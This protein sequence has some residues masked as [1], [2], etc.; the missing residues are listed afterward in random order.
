LKDPFEKTMSGGFERLKFLHASGETEWTSTG[1]SSGVMTYVMSPN[2]SRPADIPASEPIV[3]ARGDSILPFPPAAIMHLL[4]RDE[5][6][7][8]ELDPTI[9]K[10]ILIEEVVPDLCRLE[11]MK[12]KGV[13]MT[14][15]RDFAVASGGVVDSKAAKAYLFSTSLEHEKVP[16]AKGFVRGRLEVGAWVLEPITSLK[17]YDG[18][19]KKLGLPSYPKLPENEFLGA[20]RVSYLFRLSIG[21]SLPKFLVQQISAAQAK[22]PSLVSKLLEGRFPIATPK[23]RAALKSAIAALPESMATFGVAGA[24]ADV[25]TTSSSHSTTTTTTAIDA[26][27]S[28]SPHLSDTASHA[29]HSSASVSTTV[30][31]PV[32]DLTSHVTSTEHSHDISDKPLKQHPYPEVSFDLSGTW[33]VDKATSDTLEELLKE[34]GVPWI[35]RKAVEGLEVTTILRQ[36][37]SSEL[38]IE[39]RSRLGDHSSKISLNWKQFDVKGGDGKVVKVQ[40]IALSSIDSLEITSDAVAAVDAHLKSEASS[41]ST[42]TKKHC[43][44]G[45]GCIISTSILPGNLGVTYVQRHLVK[46]NLLRLITVYVKEGK[47]RAKLTR[48]LH[49]LNPETLHVLPQVEA[50]E[51]HIDEKTSA[52]VPK[53]TSV[54]PPLSSPSASLSTHETAT[55]VDPAGALSPASVGVTPH[56]EKHLHGDH[57]SSIESPARPTQPFDSSS[58]RP[59][60]VSSA[61]ETSHQPQ[62]VALHPEGWNFARWIPDE[63]VTKCET[64][65]LGFTGLRRLHHCRS[66]GLAFCGSCSPSKLPLMHFSPDARKKAGLKDKEPV[67]VCVPCAAPFVLSASTCGSAGGKVTLFGGNLGERGSTVQIKIASPFSKPVAIKVEPSW[68]KGTHTSLTFVMPPGV[69]KRDIYLTVDDRTLIGHFDYFYDPIELSSIELIESDGGNTILRGKNLPGTNAVDLRSLEVRVNGQLCPVLRCFERYTAVEINAPP[70]TGGVEAGNV[71]SVAVT[72]CAGKKP[73]HLPFS[74]APPHIFAVRLVEVKP[75]SLQLVDKDSIKINPCIIL[76]GASF[77]ETAVNI[78][79]TINGDPCEDL[80]LLVPHSKVRATVPKSVLTR[81]VS[82]DELIVCATVKGVKGETIKTNFV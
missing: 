41:P 47:V 33:R 6:S 17:S 23:G 70:G 76:Y 9:D 49:R 26:P 25:S 75:M 69:G 50:Q 81:A 53:P 79:L 55:I 42:P 51:T 40:A 18:L 77:G 57:P 5:K 34:M 11:H 10:K 48:Y 38:V 21:G 82:G 78:S 12:Y 31:T 39:E 59:P 28:P 19:A 8:Y 68:E 71:V 61:A 15:P 66:C 7:A 29:T 43:G 30:A 64:C 37:G 80:V 58:P 56:T 72:G 13:A 52:V 2:A 67:R 1:I 24:G 32:K 16:K 63:K 4:S 54:S 62:N 65:K 22:T 45:S 36:T 35:A 3:G 20:C 46:P 74:Y 60:V 44:P 14:D 27:L 73:A